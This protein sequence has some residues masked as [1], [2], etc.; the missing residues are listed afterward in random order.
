[1]H[2][3]D[4]PNHAANLFVD[5]DPV[6]GTPGTVVDDDWLNA[7]QEEIVYVIEQAGIV[8][9]KGTNTQLLAAI[10]KVF[11][12]PYAADAG[13]AN[14]YVVTLAPAISAYVQ[15]MAIRMK[16]ANTNTGASTLNA[17]GVGAAAILNPDGSPLA[18]G[19]IPANGMMVLIYDNPNFILVNPAFGG[20]NV[21]QNAIV[22]FGFTATID[23]PV[24]GDIEIALKQ[25]DGAADATERRP[26]II[27]ISGRRAGH[28]LTGAQTIKLDSTDGLGLDAYAANTETEL[29]IYLI[30]RGGTPAYG[31]GRRS[32]YERATADFVNGEGTATSRD[33]VFCTAAITVGDP[34]RVVGHFKAT[35]N[36]TTPDWEAVTAASIVVGPPPPPHP[37]SL[38][39]GWINFNGIGTI[40]IR[41]SFNVASITDNGAGDYTITWDTDFASA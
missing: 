3:T 16:A 14:A 38:G 23:T 6:G 10:K 33:H 19:E 30:D 28:R 34:C 39:K 11:D 35:Y 31:A 40:A 29:F 5:Q 24:A 9:A 26:A 18:G 8:L 20:V 41:D 15:G 21:S 4:A 36:T 22:N 12:Q 13:A 27:G 32:D 37:D 17:N 1:M 25:G 7:V 2:R